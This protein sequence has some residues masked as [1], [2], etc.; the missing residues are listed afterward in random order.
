MPPRNATQTLIS[1]DRL[2]MKTKLKLYYTFLRLINFKVIKVPLCTFR[3][4][5]IIQNGGVFQL[6]FSFKS[7]ILLLGF[8]KVIRQADD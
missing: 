1:A 3:D 4:R 7:Q 5:F 2:Q 8:R 6:L